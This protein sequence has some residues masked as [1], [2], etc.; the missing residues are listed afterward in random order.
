MATFLYNEDIETDL[1]Y[2]HSGK[3]EQVTMQA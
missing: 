3:K 1:I 2:E